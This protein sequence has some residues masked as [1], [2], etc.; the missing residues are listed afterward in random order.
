MQAKYSP[1]KSAAFALLA[2]GYTK[3]AYANGTPG[4]VYIFFGVVT[5]LPGLIAGLV[6][7]FIGMTLKR[8]LISCCAIFFIVCS[9]W[10]SSVVIPATAGVFFTAVGCIPLCIVLYVAHTIAKALKDPLGAQS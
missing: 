2:F 8:T 3:S 6:C 10:A 9:A 1:I 4:L 5:V 7:G